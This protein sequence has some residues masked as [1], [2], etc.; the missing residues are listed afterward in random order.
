MSDTCGICGTS[1]SVHSDNCVIGYLNG[2]REYV[3]KVKEI[4]LAQVQEGIRRREVGESSGGAGEESGEGGGQGYVEGP[5]T[6]PL[7]SSAESDAFVRNICWLCGHRRHVAPGGSARFCE[8]PGCGC[9]NI[10]PRPKL[11]AMCNHKKHAEVD[12]YLYG[13]ETPGCDCPR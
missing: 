3:D 6:R 11:C 5:G 4:Q 7:L 12:R 8:A 13:C 10:E 2:I 1:D 9:C